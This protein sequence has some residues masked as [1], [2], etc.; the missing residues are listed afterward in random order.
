M[1]FIISLNSQK[2]K[3]DNVVVYYSRLDCITSNISMISFT[4][5][6]KAKLITFQIEYMR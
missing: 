3:E 5:N 1:V 4:L 2:E 6:C